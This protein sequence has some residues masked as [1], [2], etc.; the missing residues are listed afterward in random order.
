M[1]YNPIAQIIPKYTML[2]EDQLFEK[3]NGLEK[4]E[5]DNCQFI[6]CQFGNAFLNNFSFLDCTFT[7]CDFSMAN[8]GGTSFKDVTF[9]DCKLLGV[10]FND[11]NPFLLQLNLNRCNVKLG[12]FFG[13]KLKKSRFSDCILEDVDFTDAD[14]SGIS[15]PNCDFREAIF[16][17]TALEKADLRTAINYSIDP[18]RN[19]ITRA[20]FAYP[21]V[22]GLLDAYKIE[23]Q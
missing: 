22:L 12:S 7:G 2:F 9:N 8:V 4:A 23:V 15:F 1:E 19:T 6:N 5:Y 18:G 20:K 21:A 17:H 3:V 13:L 14:L 10:N 16:N 11:C